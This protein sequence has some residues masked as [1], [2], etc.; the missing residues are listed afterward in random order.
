[1]ARAIAKFVE[2]LRE[3][4]ETRKQGNKVTRKRAIVCQV[5]ALKAA[6]G[7]NRKQFRIPVK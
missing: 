2:G 5:V 6:P 4:K 3:F 1:M 7:A